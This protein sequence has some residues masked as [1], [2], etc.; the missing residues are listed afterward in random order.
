[1]T[2]EDRIQFWCLENVE[3]LQN[4][5]ESEREEFLQQTEVR[6][7]KKGEL[8][9]Q[10]GDPCE[11]VYFLEEG[12]VKIS[13]VSPA[14]R[15]L[16][17]MMLRGRGQP[18]GV[19]ALAECPQRELFA[20]ALED[21]RI[22]I[23]PKGKLIRFAQENSLVCCK[24]IKLMGSRISEIRMKLEDLVFKTVPQ[25]LA[26]LLLK[27][28]DEYG[29]ETQEGRRI[30]VVFTQQELAELIGASREHV[31][32]VLKSFREEGA[33]AF[34]PKRRIL[35]RDERALRYRAGV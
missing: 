4:L 25:R 17:L 35:V 26:T 20:Q 21:S 32:S 16:T 13:Q 18:F 31:V 29:E 23:T 19:L 34:D 2:Q 27:L 6:S 33:I 1:M 7:Y 3:F 12:V 15:H 9:F 22:C 8:I 28:T 10:P 5:T 11:A 14:G 30:S 24:I